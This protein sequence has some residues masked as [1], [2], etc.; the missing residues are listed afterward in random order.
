MDNGISKR[1]LALQAAK[2]EHADSLP[3]DDSREESNIIPFSDVPDRANDGEGP[4]GDITVIN[5][6]KGVGKAQN[7]EG[8]VDTHLID[9]SL[10]KPAAPF[11]PTVATTTTTTSTTTTSAT[12]ASSTAAKKPVFVGFRPT[13]L[14]PLKT[15]PR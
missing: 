1:I 10:K 13:S 12:T 7:F 14:P 4:D 8:F 5:F 11:V 3:L 2:F 9:D 15:S 6:Q